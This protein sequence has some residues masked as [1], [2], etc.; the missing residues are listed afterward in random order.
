MRSSVAVL[1]QVSVCAASGLFSVPASV[2]QAPTVPLVVPVP[3]AQ[4]AVG[5]VVGQPAPPSNPDHS[6]ACAAFVVCLAVG[7]SQGLFSKLFSSSTDT[8]ILPENTVEQAKELLERGERR[9]G[10]SFLPEE[11]LERAK[12]GSKNEKMKLEKDCTNA[13]TDI[14]EYAAAI[15][16]GQM[17]Y[18]DIASDDVDFRMKWNG[19]LHRKKH[20]GKFMMRLRTPNG[21]VNSTLFRLYAN[22]VEPFGEHG[23]IDITTRQNIQ[24]RGMNLEGAAD[25]LSALH[26]HGQTSVQTGMDNIRNVVGSPLAGIDERE[27]V[28]TRPFCEAVH[29]LIC[30]NPE[31]GEYGNPQWGNMGRKFNISISG[32]RDDFSHTFINDIGFD[33]CPHATTGEMGFNVKLGGY[34]SIKRVAESV[35]IDIWV[36]ASDN[37][38]TSVVTLCEAVLRIFRDEGDRKDRQK[39]RLM[40]VV[41]RY[42]VEAFRAKVLAE[43]ESYGRGARTDVAQPEPA[44]EFERRDSLLG[45]ATQPDGRMRVGIHVPTGRLYP[46]EARQIADLADKYSAG[47]IRLT[48]EQNM[49]L[50][51]VDAASVEAL[52]AEPSLNGT[53]LAVQPGNVLGSM[54]SCT[55]SQFCA[56]AIIETKANAEKIVARLN[57]R[58]ISPKPLRIH[59]T[60]CPNSCGQVQAADIGLMGAPAK[61]EIDGKMKAVPGVNIFVGG[62]VGEHGKLSMEPYKK[63]VPLEEEELVPEL[64]KIAVAEFGA[65]E[66]PIHD[67]F[68][69]FDLYLEEFEDP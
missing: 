13:W 62:T 14:Y 49:L 53:R 1:A 40:W 23:V 59:F 46:A 22:K 16:S 37:D 48:V 39:A 50:P 2:R 65:T 18:E 43:I 24:L 12:V 64:V 67:G 32:S 55:G 11:T 21:I 66:I 61:K 5:F 38:V 9:T 69:E 57:E 68:Q 10:T 17:N 29:N 47:E 4:P 45:V 51:N 54:V 56:L 20:P 42:G 30:K 52:L 34:M 35:P 3:V 33:P 41:E 27:L 60:G 25:I 15:R 26:E 63:G 44:E 58:I 28:D 7:G 31:T 6:L 19:I 36:P 8:S